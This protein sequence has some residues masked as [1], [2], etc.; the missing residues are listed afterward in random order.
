MQD[1]TLGSSLFTRSGTVAQWSRHTYLGAMESL[2]PVSVPRA[3][4]AFYF[5]RNNCG[6]R[7]WTPEVPLRTECNRIKFIFV[8]FLPVPMNLAVL[9]TI[10]WLPCPYQRLPC[11][12]YQPKLCTVDRRDLSCIRT[13]SGVLE[14][15]HRRQLVMNF[16]SVFLCLLLA[17]GYSNLKNIA[18]KEIDRYAP[19]PFIVFNPQ[20]PI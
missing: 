13:V 11:P 1:T 12:D 15:S 6:K 7:D 10:P 9:S 19:S 8:L 3:V 17:S 20:F 2:V 16:A 5:H 18:S 14:R 4:Y